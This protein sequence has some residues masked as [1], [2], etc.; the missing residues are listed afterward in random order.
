MP[1]ER[2]PAPPC[3][4]LPETFSTACQAAPCPKDERLRHRHSPAWARFMSLPAECRSWF[5]KVGL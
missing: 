3:F 1:L 4:P 5:P 2:G